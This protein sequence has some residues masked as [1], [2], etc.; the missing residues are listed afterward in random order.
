[1]KYI[2]DRIENNIAVCE[3]EDKKHENFPIKKLFKGIKEGDFF[4][5]TASGCIFLKE[6]TELAR[7]RNIALQNSLFE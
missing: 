3:T 5:L 4:E 1:M 2:V 6:E 7:K